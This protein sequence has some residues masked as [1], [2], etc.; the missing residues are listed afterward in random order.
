MNVFMFSLIISTI[1]FVISSVVGCVDDVDCVG[2][3]FCV[4]IVDVP[5]RVDCMVSLE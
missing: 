3:V 4:V 1:F 5:F 2:G